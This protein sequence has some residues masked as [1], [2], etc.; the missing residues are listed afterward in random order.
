MTPDHDLNTCKVCDLTVWSVGYCDKG[1][2]RKGWKKGG[3]K[4]EC[5]G[6]GGGTS[7]WSEGAGEQPQQAPQEELGTDRGSVDRDH[8][9]DAAEPL[10]GCDDSKEEGR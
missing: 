10:N 2:Q 5:G 1:C 6:K 4:Q 9:P 7:G 8:I 3:H